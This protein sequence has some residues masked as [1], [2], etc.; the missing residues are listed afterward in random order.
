MRDCEPFLG[1]MVATWW[2]RVP[3]KD[4]SVS[5]LRLH[6][7]MVVRVEWSAIGYWGMRLNIC[8]I[9]ALSV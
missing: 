8:Y 6:A 4:V 9:L 5:I 2:L 7:H 3:S 1:G